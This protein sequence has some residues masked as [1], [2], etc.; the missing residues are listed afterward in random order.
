MKYSPLSKLSRYYD[1]PWISQKGTL[2]Y[3][4]EEQR[5][6]KLLWGLQPCENNF[7]LE[8]R[9]WTATRRKSWLHRSWCTDCGADFLWLCQVYN[10]E[11]G[12]TLV[13]AEVVEAQSARFAAH[14]L[15][16]LSMVNDTWTVDCI[17]Y[18]C[19]GEFVLRCSWWACNRIEPKIVCWHHQIQAA[20]HQL[21]ILTPPT[22]EKLKLVDAHVITKLGST[23][24]SCGI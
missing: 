16:T 4:T 24:A 12:N 17:L 22:G 8:T 14:V 1:Q 7:V 6:P 20:E 19:P 5:L 15:V 2:H 18:L 10:D 23:W 11:L 3:R 21:N 9:S 13:Q